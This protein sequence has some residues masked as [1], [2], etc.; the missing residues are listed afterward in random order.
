MLCNWLQIGVEILTS[1]SVKK[2]IEL[3]ESFLG[4]MSVI[5]LSSVQCFTFRMI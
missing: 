5:R 1:M 3:K 2:Y 4:I